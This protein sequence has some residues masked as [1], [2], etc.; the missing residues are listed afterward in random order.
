MGYGGTEAQ[1]PLA[2]VRWWKTQRTASEVA[3]LL[4]GSIVDKEILEQRFAE[5]MKEN[6]M[7]KVR[8]SVATTDLARERQRLQG[9]IADLKSK[10]AAAEKA[11]Q[12]TGGG[13][14]IAESAA[15]ERLLKDE[16]E[17]IVQT[18]RVD[19]KMERQRHAN[20]LKAMKDRME[21]CM[22][23][24]FRLE[25]SVARSRLSSTLPERWAVQTSD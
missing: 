4:A 7:L 17:R 9:E 5:L 10:V 6:A 23:S 3:E 20:Q 13:R 12:N 11:P 25:K 22:C 16:F 8:C 21:G 24:E 19:L 15:R 14:L 18:L 2:D 1:S